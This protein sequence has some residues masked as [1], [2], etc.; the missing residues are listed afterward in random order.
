M[1]GKDVRVGRIEGLQAVQQLGRMVREIFESYKNPASF[2]TPVQSPSRPFTSGH[3]EMVQHVPGK[4][5]EYASHKQK[6]A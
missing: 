4:R 2:S 3:F 5:S 6:C 1:S